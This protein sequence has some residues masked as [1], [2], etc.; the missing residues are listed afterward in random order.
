MSQSGMFQQDHCDL[1]MITAVELP[2]HAPL[3]TSL[4]IYGVSFIR[5]FCSTAVFSVVEMTINIHSRIG[6]IRCSIDMTS[7]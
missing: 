1:Q 2:A 4:V 5:D 3:V 6:N 7:Y